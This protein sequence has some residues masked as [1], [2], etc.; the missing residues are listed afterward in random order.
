MTFDSYLATLFTAYRKTVDDE[1]A[2]LYGR[3]L[4]DIPLRLLDRAIGRAIRT[5]TWLPTVAELR[6]DAEAERRALL[7]AHPYT[8]CAGCRENAGWVAVIDTDGVARV[9]RCGC[10]ARWRDRLAQLG[11]TEDAVLALPAASEA[12]P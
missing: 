4:D 12:T 8:P 1:A 5:R 10:F 11:V 3:G 9:R 6:A 7:Q 2:A